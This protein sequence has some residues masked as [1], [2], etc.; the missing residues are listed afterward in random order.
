MSFNGKIIL[1]LIILSSM[2]G[3][4]FFGLSG[5]FLFSYF[6]DYG[7]PSN[8]E[9]LNGALLGVL[10]AIPCWIV[11]SILSLLVRKNGLGH[12]I[13]HEAPI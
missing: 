3:I 4:F 10:P 13:G 8:Y 11:V 6:V 2:T 1:G 9:N 12:K 5:L 7:S